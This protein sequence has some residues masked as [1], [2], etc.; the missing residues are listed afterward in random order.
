MVTNSS[1]PRIPT[2]R[3]VM[4]QFDQDETALESEALSR[5]EISGGDRKGTDDTDLLD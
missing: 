3:S 1:V 4:D 2:D 5:L